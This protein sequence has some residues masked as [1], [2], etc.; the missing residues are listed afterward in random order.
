MVKWLDS[1]GGDKGWEHLDKEARKALKPAT[2]VTV[3]RVYDLRK[4]HLTVVLS[5]DLTWGG[6]C[7]TITIPHCCILSITRLETTDG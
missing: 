4:K 1:N 3:G 5:E 7:G 2:V 6:V